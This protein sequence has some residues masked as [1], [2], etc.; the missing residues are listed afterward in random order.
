MDGAV[1]IDVDA[2]VDVDV[3]KMEKDNTT[4]KW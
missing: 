1:D 4:D 3:G 2:D